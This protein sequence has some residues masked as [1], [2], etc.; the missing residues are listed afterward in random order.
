M[1]YRS[2]Y[3]D[4]DLPQ[5]NLLTYLFPEHKIT[6]TPLWISAEDPSRSLSSR[7]M[8]AWIKRLGIGLDKL[9]V[10]EGEVVLIF[11]PNHIFVPCAYLGIVGSKRI[12]SGGNPSYTVAEMTHQIAD[13]DARVILV[14][15]DL[16]DT[17]L[18]A[19]TAAAQ[20]TGKSV[21]Q[22]FL[23][24]DEY[25][26]P[27]RGIY[28]WQ[29]FI[30]TPAEADR[31]QIKPLTPTEAVNTVATV[32]YSSGTT[33]LPKG[34]CVSHANLIANLEQ[35]FYTRFV[36]RGYTWDDFPPER[37]LAFL[38]LYHA[39][40]QLFTNM[41]VQRLQ[42]PCYIMKVFNFE[43]YLQHIQNYRITNLQV[44]PPILVM[45]QKRPETANYDIS[46]VTDILTGAAPLPT[47]LAREVS[48]RFN[49]QINSGWGMTEVT[50][51]AILVPGGTVDFTGSIGHIIPN[52]EISMRDDNGN[53]VPHG[54]RGELYVRG[55]QVCMRYWK[56]EEATRETL[57]EGGWLK[58]GDIAIMRNGKFWIVDRKKEMIKVNAL[59]VAPAE[60]EAV[61][62]E[63][64]AI[65]DSAVT[66]IQ[67]HGQEW[68]RAY[69][70]LA[71]EATGKVSE[72]DIHKWFIKR[73]AKHKRLAGGIMFV[74]EI[75]KLA[76][77]KI[78]RQIMREWAKRDIPEMERKVKA[79]L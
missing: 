27:I 78:K 56:N 39:Y 65:I 57:L 19:A 24:S 10:R 48:E 6:D 26:P 68:P 73:V 63:H 25:V 75:P 29:T 44:A 15:P 34:V 59:Q 42:I 13:T 70:T 72:E 62:L 60:L 58:T 11:T 4:L 12:F 16:I 67:L 49:V 3:P 30:G 21:P 46:S 64:E 23:F 8:L 66:G 18:P 53:E 79:R 47:E 69:V 17:A 35:N 55:P 5:C 31:A 51:G 54:H 9:G 7:Q 22:L 32:N 20:R 2:P 50:C 61:L 71:P 76:S 74:D 77:G 45:L 33:G 38:P 1:V 41:G 14:H 36:G 40:G 28:D 43:R 37:W 52:T